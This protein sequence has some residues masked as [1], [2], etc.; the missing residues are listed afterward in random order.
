MGL[1]AI[2]TRSRKRLPFSH[3]NSQIAGVTHSLTHSAAAA[4]INLS[5][6]RITARASHNG[7][8]NIQT[9]ISARELLPLFSAKQR[10][11]AVCTRSN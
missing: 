8:E 2:F 4:V 5:A 6:G 11:S 7:G 9:N 10:T 1:F 3:L